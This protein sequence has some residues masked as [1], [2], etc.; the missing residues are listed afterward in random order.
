M[1]GKSGQNL[2]K[3][4]VCGQSKTWDL[5]SMKKAFY[6][7]IYL[8]L[9]P[10]VRGRSVIW[11]Q[12]HNFKKMQVLTTACDIK[13]CLLA[14]KLSR[15]L[16]GRVYVGFWIGTRRWK[17]LMPNFKMARTPK[18]VRTSGTLWWAH[19]RHKNRI[20]CMMCLLCATCVQITLRPMFE[21]DSKST[22][23]FLSNEPPSVKIGHS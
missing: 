10:K 4:N 5:L 15:E 18:Y 7:H 8:Q 16:Q 22:D 11:P 3:K 2:K 13:R 1:I 23:N 14:A 9:L 20:F 21:S 12:I 6:S 17:A 19:N